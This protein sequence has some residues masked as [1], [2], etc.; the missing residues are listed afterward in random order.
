MRSPMVR[1]LSRM[2][3]PLGRIALVASAMMLA[4]TPLD[5]QN[6]NRHPDPRFVDASMPPTSRIR[7]AGPRAEPPATLA[8]A[9]VRIGE[10]TGPDHAI[11]GEIVAA[12]ITGSGTIVVVDG[13]IQDV[14]TFDA[15]GRFLHRLGRG[16]RGPGEFLR[17]QALLISVGDELWVSDMQRRLTIYAPSTAS[18]ALSRTLPT[19]VGIR[20][21]CRLGNELFVNG[22]SMTDAFVVR[23]IGPAGR[24]IR[25]FGKIYASPNPLVNYQFAEGRV[26]CD[27]ENGIVAYASAAAL[28]EIRGY[29]PD[30]T[31]LWRTLVEDLRHN[32]VTDNQ[33]GGVTV[34]RNPEGAH[35]LLSLHALP[36]VGF[37]VQYGHRTPEQMKARAPVE[38]IVT[39]FLDPRTGSPTVSST[40]WPRV[41]AVS[42]TSALLLFEDPAPRLE[43]RAL[44][45]RRTPH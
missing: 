4:A 34:A 23:V 18:Y 37:L 27:A 3:R 33:D 26:A 20:S 30:G 10:E 16:G 36:A 40:P 14:R 1:V 43:L 32:L 6:A 2:W 5:A 22:V 9:L 42:R 19:D 35:S 15:S 44:R 41:G 39:L 29:R 17:P 38:N 24:A 12:G 7:I 21:M 13:Q 25:S 11:F 28:G 45:T 8:G 31:L